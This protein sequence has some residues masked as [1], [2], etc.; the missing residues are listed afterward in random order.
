[1]TSRDSAVHVPGS[2]LVKCGVVLHCGPPGSWDAGM[3]ESPVVWYDHHRKSFGMVYTGYARG[4]LAER[5]YASV[6]RP[7][8]GLAWSKDLV[9]WRKDPSSPIFGPSD[10]V[11][12][13]DRAGTAGPCIW[14]EEGCYHLFYFGVTEEGYEK[15]TKTLNLAVSRDLQHWERHG[16]NPIICPGGDGWRRDAIWHPHVLKVSSTYYLFFN[17]SGIHRGVEEE[18]IGYATS[19]DLTHWTVDDAQSPVLVGSMQAE[20]W[21]STGRAGDPSIY[22][23]HDLWYMAYYSWDGIHSQDGI[24]WTTEEEFPLGWRPFEGNPVLRVGEAG[25]YDA[26]HAAKPHIIEHAYRHHHFYTAV[27]A[28]EKREIALAVWPGPC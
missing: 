9:N 27:D 3:V 22:K 4:G 16:D 6:R 14:Q 18:F 11:G 24:A 21:D 13:P 5:G 15:G 7:Q 12:S 26:L 23:H 17:A 28:S 10:R 19:T 8:I 1:M 20:A 25:T 2:E